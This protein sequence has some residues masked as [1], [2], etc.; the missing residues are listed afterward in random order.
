MLVSFYLRVRI[1]LEDALEHVDECLDIEL[2]LLDVHIRVQLPLP[3]DVLDHLVEERAQAE[4]QQFV[5]KGVLIKLSRILLHQLL[6]L[7][8]QLRHM[9]VLVAL[10]VS[11]HLVHLFQEYLKFLRRIVMCVCACFGG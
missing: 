1:R 3:G 9:W 2:L 6:N 5:L 4:V 11:Y 7:L 10:P 8:E